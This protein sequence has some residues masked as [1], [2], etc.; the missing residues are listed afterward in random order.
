MGSY[1]RRIQGTSEL[2]LGNRTSHSDVLFRGHILLI[3]MT[4][5]VSGRSF[6]SRR[7]MYLTCTSDSDA[8]SLQRLFFFREE[9]GR[10]KKYGAKVERL[11]NVYGR[12][13]DWID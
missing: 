2:S 8:A 6:T 3:H 11:S 13:A 10:P 9:L 12:L 5:V 1:Q 4:Y 7:L